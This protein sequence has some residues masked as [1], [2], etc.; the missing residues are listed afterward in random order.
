MTSIVSRW[1]I[2]DPPD[3]DV[4]ERLSAELDVPRILAALLAQR[5]YD[6]PDSAKRFLRPSLD[7]LHNPFLLRDMDRAVEIISRAVASGESILIHGD[8]DVDG[9]CATVKRCWSRRFQCIS[10]T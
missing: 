1:R 2:G 9:Q 8:Y 6:T 7:S 4:V 3:S 5:G 10:D